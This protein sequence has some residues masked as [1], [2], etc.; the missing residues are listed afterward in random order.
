MGTY[1]K[2]IRNLDI[3]YVLSVCIYL[4]GRVTEKNGKRD[5]LTAD[6]LPK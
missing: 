1:T 5:F 3:Y 4:E 2:L 6:L